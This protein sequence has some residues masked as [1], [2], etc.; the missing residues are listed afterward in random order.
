M[1]KKNS[2]II[3]LICVLALIFS[4]SVALPMQRISKFGKFGKNIYQKRKNYCKKNYQTVLPVA[5]IS[6]SVL[7]NSPYYCA[8]NK[9]NKGG[10]KIFFDTN[11]AAKYAAP[12]FSFSL[13]LS[14]INPYARL[15]SGIVVTTPLLNGM[16][17]V[18]NKTEES[19]KEPYKNET[20]LT[21]C[22]QLPFKIKQRIT[23]KQDAKNDFPD[24]HPG[25]P[26]NPMFFVNK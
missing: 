15:I 12:A 13:V 4:A 1:V 5:L 21:K 6:G 26:N 25:N 9:K 11:K 3:G 22:T 14:I 17:Y 23:S 10:K 2:N 16:Y 7:N 24:D 8:L 18:L 20:L 19:V